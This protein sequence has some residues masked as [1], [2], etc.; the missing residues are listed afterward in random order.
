MITDPYIRFFPTLSRAMESIGLTRDEV[1][2]LHADL[3]IAGKVTV[4]RRR[5]K[6]FILR[7]REHT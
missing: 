4:Q 7:R 2:E 6:E 5:L 3:I 1:D